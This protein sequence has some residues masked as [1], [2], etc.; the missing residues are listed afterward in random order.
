MC[1]CVHN[2]RTFFFLSSIYIVTIAMP[3]TMTPKV[4]PCIKFTRFCVFVCVLFS[5]ICFRFGSYIFLFV[6]LVFHF[7]FHRRLFTRWKSN[8]NKINQIQVW[9]KLEWKG[10]KNKVWLLIFYWFLFPALFT[11]SHRLVCGNQWRKKFQ[12][13]YF[14]NFQ[15]SWHSFWVSIIHSMNVFA[16][17][18]NQIKFFTSEQSFH[19]D[20]QNRCDAIPISS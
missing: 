2:W 10:K 5:F 1:V 4:P 9:R 16:I 17:W 13:N 14:R 15:T 19:S 12:E 8:V 3:D 7:M 11:P 18:S 6:F 20:S